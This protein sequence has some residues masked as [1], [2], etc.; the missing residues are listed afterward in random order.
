MT[1]T[2][3]RQSID[4][5]SRR[6]SDL[7]SF[8]PTIIKK[9]FHSPE[10]DRLR[11]SI[12][13][14][15]SRTFGEG[16]PDRLRYG[17]ASYFDEGPIN[18]GGGFGGREFPISQVHARVQDSK[19][20]NIALLEQAIEVLRERLSEIDDPSS[21]PADAQSKSATP[22]SNRVFIVHGHDSEAKEAVA[23]LLEK[24]G[25]DPVILHEKPNLGRTIIEKFEQEG[26]VGFAV[27]LL[28]PDDLGKAK[29]DAELEPRA[30]QN[31]ILELGYFVGTLG[32]Q[33]V[34]A[35]VRQ[36][37]DLPSDFAGVVY[38]RFDDGGAWKLILGRELRAAGYSI[39]MNRI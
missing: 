7:R 11:T 9:R 5:L 23:R 4:R 29:T 34:C 6:L 13:E 8:D 38:E 37:V 31:V 36:N 18:L 14:A 2:H 28:T 27:V 25:L 39:D 20:S 30:R 1:P 17:S 26:D 16:T 35:L 19:E 24:L 12:D 21:A 33:K 32:R 15:L 3:L 22:L 10:L